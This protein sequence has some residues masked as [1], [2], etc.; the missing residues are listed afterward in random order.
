VRRHLRNFLFRDVLDFGFRFVRIGFH[1]SQGGHSALPGHGAGRQTAG[2]VFARFGLVRQRMTVARTDATGA[3]G[4]DPF[5]LAFTTSLPVDKALY[6]SDI[7]GSLAHARMLEDRGILPPTDGAALRQGL[8]TLFDEIVAGKLAWPPEED[9]HMAIESELTKRVGDPGRRL[10]TARS[11]NDQIALDGRLHLREQTADAL[12]KIAVLIDLLVQR[13]EG[14]EGAYLMPAYTHRQRAQPVTVGYTLS[15]YAQMLARDAAQFSQVLNALDECPLGVGAVSGTSLPT[16]RERTA[17]LLAF[18]RVTENGLDTVGDRDFALDFTFATAKCLVHL[19]RISQD[20]VDFA[21][22][23][24]GFIKLANEIS[25]GS[26]MMPQKKN[27]DLFELL[28][29]KSSRALAAHFGLFTTVKGLP[30]GYM[31]DLQEDKVSYLESCELLQGSLKAM[32]HG[33][34]GITFQKDRLAIGVAGGETQAT[35]LAERLVARGL[36]FRDA[37]KAVGALVQIAV[38][39]GRPLGA[40]TEKD[41]PAGSP[42]NAQ[43]LSSLRPDTA[44]AAKENTGG[45][46]PR[47]VALQLEHLKEAASGARTRAKATPRLADLIRKLG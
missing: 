14:P 22:Q 37:Y 15:A 9:V 19:S 6:A 16:Q 40:L 35:D 27:P 39:S 38:T 26:S 25:F 28:R 8:K 23:E 30:V 11:R 13:A 47:A 45:T 29:G 32:E 10:H 24:F 43:D 7:A 42:L 4:L 33:I 36:A 20:M 12:E 21:S 41:L 2:G 3:G 46:G 17:E 44:A 1:A 5:V 34:K 31:R 18:S